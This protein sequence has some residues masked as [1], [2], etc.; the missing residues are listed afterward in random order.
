[1]T[2]MD[3]HA[4][5]LLGQALDVAAFADSF[6]DKSLRK[7][8]EETRRGSVEEYC[9]LLARDAREGEEF[10]A[11]LHI[12]Y[13]E[14]F[15]N[16]LTFATLEHI[17]LPALIQRKRNAKH[18]EIRI[19]STACAAGQEAY[20]LAILLE[21]L[22][23]GAKTDINYRIFA[24]DRSETQL[25]AARR[26]QYAATAVGNLNLRRLRQWFTTHGETYTV[27]PELRKNIDFSVFDLLSGQLSSP[28][29]SIFGD[30]DL[31]FCANLLFYYKPPYQKTIL[32]KADNTLARDG[33]LVVGETERSI[34]INHGNLEVYPQSAIYNRK[35]NER[36]SDDE[37]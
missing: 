37:N 34:L 9:A 28:R 32:D 25:D 27:K 12:N 6:L 24:T 10:L 4:V 14:F 13:S 3:K 7:R 2:P 16:S 19:W 18:K 31:V 20:S 15:R 36:A 11:A 22:L 21:E 30:F 35:Q 26:G 17:V 23:G 5:E 29:A 33:V 1:M 8:M